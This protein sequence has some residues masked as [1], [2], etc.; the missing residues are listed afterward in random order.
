MQYV[1]KLS[2]EKYFIFL[3]GKKNNKKNIFFLMALPL[4]K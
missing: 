1:E 3:H 4:G 2:R